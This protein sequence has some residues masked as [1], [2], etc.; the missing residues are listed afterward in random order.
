MFK[1]RIATVVL[2]M[3]VSSFSPY[4]LAQN[5]ASESLVTDTS[6]TSYAGFAVEEDKYFQ[7]AQGL[8]LEATKDCIEK[9]PGKKVVFISDKTPTAD[10]RRVIITN[11]TGNENNYRVF[12]NDNTAP[13]TDKEY[14]QDQISEDIT[15]AIGSQHID[16]KLALIEG[17]NKLKYEIVEIQ[18]IDGQEFETV[19]ETGHFLVTVQTPESVEP[20]LD[21][22][23][24]AL[25]PDYSELFPET[26][27]AKFPVSEEDS[28][29][30]SYSA[31]SWCRFR[32][33]EEQHEQERLQ[34]Q[35]HQENLQRQFEYE[36][37]RR[38]DMIRDVME[39]SDSKYLND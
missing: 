8:V 6:Q 10:N 16:R 14:E 26:P 20:T 3:S 21:S 11:I 30:K 4:V 24:P 9:A 12:G 17:E 39:D 27:Q 34:E 15:V 28:F 5:S 7:A 33:M 2:G 32:E 35:L 36:Q 22:F 25:T 18:E 1:I 23:S 19:L 31:S 38:E 29:S 13:H 37:E